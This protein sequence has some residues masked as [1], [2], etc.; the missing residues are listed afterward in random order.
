MKNLYVGNLPYQVDETQLQEC[1]T[2]EGFTVESVSLI[3]DRYSGASRGFAFVSISNDEEAERAI[4]ALNGKDL[5]GRALVVNEARPRR[6]SGDR[7]RGQGGGGGQ[8]R[9]W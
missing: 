9:N 8:S 2:Q 3:R 5:S 7:G 6:E 4:Q 1:F